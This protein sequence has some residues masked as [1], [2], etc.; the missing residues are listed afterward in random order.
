MKILFLNSAKKWGGNEHWTSLAAHGLAEQHKVYVAYRSQNIGYRFHVKKFWLPFLNELDLFTI[1]RLFYLIKT[2]EI[3][4]LIPTKRKD[5]ILAGLA[6]S[7][8]GVKNV[9]RLGIE[10]PI[11]NTWIN[12]LI[13]NGMCDGIIVNAE[14]VKTRLLQPGFISPEKIRVIYNGVDFSTVHQKSEQKNGFVKPFDFT[15]VAMGELSQRKG[16]DLL[17]KAFFKLKN[18]KKSDKR[19]GLMIIGSGPEE[20]DLM[21]LVQQLEINEDVVFTGFLENPYPVI[22]GCDIFVQTSTTEGI[23]NAMLESMALKKPII[24]A[25]FGAAHEVIQNGSNGYLL[26][27]Q[28]AAELANRLAA[29]IDDQNKRDAIAKEGFNSVRHIFS[30]ERMIGEIEEFCDQVL[31]NNIKGNTEE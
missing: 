28:D 5:Y 15:I 3:E 23:P 22:E 31:E 29:L 14:S 27:Q 17:L 1:F 25:E 11:K 19:F 4:I 12:R 26:Q 8:T 18:Q 13:Y 21:R 24:T 10:R 2:E 30:M 20:Q 16:F 7:A 9:L 6:A